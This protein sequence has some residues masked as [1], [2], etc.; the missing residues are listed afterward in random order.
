MNTQSKS[1]P[2]N[3]LCAL[4]REAVEDACS[5]HVERTRK[6]ESAAYNAALNRALALAG[7]NTAMRDAI[8]DLESAAGALMVAAQDAAL[9]WAWP[10]K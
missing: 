4:A 8:F 2:D 7:A 6:A 3:R 9:W 10:R 5:A 1:V